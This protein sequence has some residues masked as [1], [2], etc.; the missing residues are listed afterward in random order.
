MKNLNSSI[1]SHISKIN[2]LDSYL[3]VYT[4]QE[5]KGGKIMNTLKLVIPKGRLNKKVIGVLNDAGLGIETDERRYIPRVEADGI[6]AK[7]MKPQNIP[8]LVEVGS[9][10]VGFTG[11][12][13]IKE[14][15]ADVLEVLDLGFN[16]V[17]IVAAAPE[18]LTEDDLLSRRIIVASEYESIANLFLKEKGF[19]Y[20][21][22][23]TFGATEVFPPDDADII[24]DNMSSGRTLEEHKL[25]VL[26]RIMVSTT[27][28]IVNK[29]AWE[30]DEKRARIE[31]LIMLIKAVLDAEERVMIE[32]NINADKLDA[33]VPELPCMRAPTVSSLYA[34]EGYAVKIAVK[35]SE[36]WTLIPKLKAM[37]ASDILEYDIRKVV[38]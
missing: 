12:D 2:F 14:T 38:S 4:G 31:E 29:K 35:K 19:D 6:E 18:W 37:G 10:D 22:I 24:I 11:H 36:T 21:F 23:R 34:G 7:I 3:L 17:S 16:P 26:H 9:H 5:I 32:M 30:D 8:Q 33:M 25:R 1:F 28:M 20:Y 27:R 13:W 15:D